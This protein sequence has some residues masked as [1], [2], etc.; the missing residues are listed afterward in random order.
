MVL[1]SRKLV[2]HNSL[3]DKM[4]HSAPFYPNVG[5]KWFVKCNIYHFAHS[6]Q[7]LVYSYDSQLNQYIGIVA[8]FLPNIILFG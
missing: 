5:A 1:K 6:E 8:L 7:S 4:A 2:N 3:G